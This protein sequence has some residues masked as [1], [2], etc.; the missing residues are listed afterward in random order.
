MQP[1]RKADP[2]GCD[3]RRRCG[4]REAAP[5][6]RFTILGP[7]PFCPLISSLPFALVCELKVLRQFDVLA[8]LFFRDLVLLSAAYREQKCK[9]PRGSEY[10][11]EG[12]PCLLL[13]TSSHDDL[14]KFEE[15]MIV[16]VIWIK[17]VRG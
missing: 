5:S 16:L 8:S 7:K 15:Y 2:L 6:Q 9:S 12:R 4:E 17:L 14:Q 10:F 3:S 13:E 11:P 1:D